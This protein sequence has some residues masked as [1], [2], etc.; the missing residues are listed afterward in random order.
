MEL[1]DRP[2]PTVVEGG[3]LP[4]P[5]RCGVS[6]LA[7]PEVSDP[8]LEAYAKDVDRSLLI[9]NLRL[10][11]AQRAQRFTDFMMFLEEIQRAGQRLREEA[12]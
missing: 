1:H 6:E 11:P 12:P 8:V 3:D 10:T 5:P 9:D 4:E 7:A 2:G